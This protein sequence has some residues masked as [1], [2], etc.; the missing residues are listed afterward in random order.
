MESTST[1][2]ISATL[3]DSY[4]GQNVI[5]VGKVVQLRGDTAFLEADGQIQ[6]NLNRDCHLMVGNGAQIIGKVNPDLSIKV[7]NAI[8]LGNNVDFQLCQNVVDVT[9]QFKDIFHEQQQHKYSSQQPKSQPRPQPQPQPQPQFIAQPAS[10]QKQKITSVAEPANDTAFAVSPVSTAS[11][12]STSSWSSR[13]ITPPTSQL[14]QLSIQERPRSPQLT[15]QQS[16]I[17]STQPTQ[18]TQFSTQPTQYSTQNTQETQDTQ[19][20]TYTEYTEEA[21]SHQR[22]ERKSS[23]RPIKFQPP[24][25]QLFSPTPPNKP[26]V[27]STKSQRISTPPRIPASPPSAVKPPPSLIASPSPPPIANPSPP[28]IVSPSPP[29]ITS[30]SPSYLPTLPFALPFS[31]PW[32]TA[33]R[34][35]GRLYRTKSGNLVSSAELKRRRETEQHAD[36]L[37]DMILE[38]FSDESSRVITFTLDDEGRWRIVR[39]EVVEVE[40]YEDR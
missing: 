9:H 27:S 25:E 36:E 20:T 24:P 12:I 32:P 37:L 17:N 15:S 7:L 13:V 14:V 26:S 35:R 1:P 39:R 31:I 18:S 29:R 22:R 33:P 16:N 2:R 4:V 5:I 19:Y 38:G 10:Q 40:L 34:P 3:M 23:P 6:A 21:T 8:D 28:P 11:I 30:P